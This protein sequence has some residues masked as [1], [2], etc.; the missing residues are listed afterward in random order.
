MKEKELFPRK[1]RRGSLDPLE[2]SLNQGVRPTYFR[3]FFRT[4]HKK[5]GVIF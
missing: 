1:A 2:L 4:S 5:G 3:L